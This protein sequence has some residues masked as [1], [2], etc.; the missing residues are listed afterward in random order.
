M[1][2]HSVSIAPA[3]ANSTGTPQ[4]LNVAGDT[5]AEL[6]EQLAVEHPSLRQSLTP[7]DGRLPKYIRIFVDGASCTDAHHGEALKP[8]TQ[9][10]IV[11]AVAGG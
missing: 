2:T 3:L 5:V 8:G 10:M 11:S 7:V 4:R 6:L 9:V 1:S